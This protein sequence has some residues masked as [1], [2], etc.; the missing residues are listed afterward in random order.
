MQKDALN[1][2]RSWT[3]EASLHAS[4]EQYR[5]RC[6]S[7]P[8]STAKT[9]R[10]CVAILPKRCFW[11]PLLIADATGRAEVKFDLSDSVTTYRVL[12][13]AHD[14]HGRIGGGKGE[15]ISR[16]PFN[17]EPKMPLEVTAGDHIELPVA[18]ANDT[19]GS[20]R[21]S[22]HSRQANYSNSAANRNAN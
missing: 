22:S 6:G 11:H 14:G 15:V 1:W 16:I 5:F 13:D 18:V 10:A 9:S 3:R 17:L 21:Y 7:M 8:I 2:R 12:V 4:L 20:C 19:R